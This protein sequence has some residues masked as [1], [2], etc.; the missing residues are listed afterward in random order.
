MQSAQAFQQMAMALS[1]PVDNMA[2]IAEWRASVERVLSLVSALDKLEE[3]IENVC[4]YYKSRF[5]SEFM[6]M[7]Y[8]VKDEWLS[9][10][11]AV[12]NIYDGT[13]RPQVVNKNRHKIFHKI[14]SAPRPLPVE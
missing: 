14:L 12:I 3:E 11:P 8:N 4:H 10:I 5:T 9:K 13:A 2:K 7:C 6:T 1:W